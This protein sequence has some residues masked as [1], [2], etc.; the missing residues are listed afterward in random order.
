VYAIAYNQADHLCAR[1]LIHDSQRVVRKG[2]RLALFGNFE[3]DRVARSNHTI[4]SCLSRRA[5]SKIFA[6]GDST[7]KFR[8]LARFLAASADCFPS[9]SGRLKVNRLDLAELGG[10]ARYQDDPLMTYHPLC[11]F[12]K[13]LQISA[14]GSRR[15]CIRASTKNPSSAY[16]GARTFLFTGCAGTA[17]R[18]SARSLL[19]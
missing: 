15:S 16:T 9:R 5:W 6:V 11:I 4:E 13:S 7:R 3:L 14:N 19:V 1:K 18:S 17:I 8:P 2:G 10:S 12:R